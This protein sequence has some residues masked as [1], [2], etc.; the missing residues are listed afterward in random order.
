[1]AVASASNVDPRMLH[2]IRKLAR[3]RGWVKIQRE[4]ERG[5]RRHGRGI[6]LTASEVAALDA[7]LLSPGVRGLVERMKAD[8]AVATAYENAAKRVAQ[9]AVNDAPRA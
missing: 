2:W 4:A 1:M 7:E 5:L 9:Q 3:R 6:Q 8:I